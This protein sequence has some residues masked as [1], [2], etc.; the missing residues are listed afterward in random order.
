MAGSRSHQQ[1]QHQPSRTWA[2]HT[3]DPPLRDGPVMGWW[4]GAAPALPG[5]SCTS[6]VCLCSVQYPD[7][8]MS[9]LD[10]WHVCRCN[11]RRWAHS[12]LLAR[13]YLA[14]LPMPYAFA[15]ARGCGSNPPGPKPPCSP[16]CPS[17]VVPVARCC[18][19]HVQGQAARTL[20]T[21]ACAASSATQRVWRSN[22]CC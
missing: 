7:V 11:A 14:N 22:R 16:V 12:R 17:V 1:P 10:C 19:A 13:S 2:E 3:A 18:T 8:A 4:A 9:Q 20:E 15:I 5:D 6:S 21:Q